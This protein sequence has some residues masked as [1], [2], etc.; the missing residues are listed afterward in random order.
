MAAV[1]FGCD[2]ERGEERSGAR[3]RG[4][5]DARVRLL[6]G[7]DLVGDGEAADGRP[8]AILGRWQWNGGHPASDEQR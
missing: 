6:V 4:T 3:E 8:V 1:A 2:G 7:G 5:G